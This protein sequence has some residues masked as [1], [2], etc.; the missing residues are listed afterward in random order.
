M[1]AAEVE[2]PENATLVR[3]VRVV[4]YLDENGQMGMGIGV[5]GEHE[6]DLIATL[7][8]LSMATNLLL[9]EG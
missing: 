1:D 5:E 3:E 9:T 4:Q 7:G 6:F 2:I 8:M